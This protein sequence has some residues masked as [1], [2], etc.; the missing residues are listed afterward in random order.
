[1]GIEETTNRLNR[2]SQAESE[3]EVGIF[4][5][6]GQLEHEKLNSQL[7]QIQ[8]EHA[9]LSAAVAGEAEAEQVAAFVKKLEE[10]IPS[11]EDRI[12]IW[13]TLRKKDALSSFLR[14]APACTTRPMMLTSPS[15]VRPCPRS[16]QA[17]SNNCFTSFGH[18]WPRRR[19]QKRSLH[20]AYTW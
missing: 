10:Q 15:E 7:L 6:Q 9:K 1:M 4:K 8:H 12:G 19:T 3:N 2:L 16:E 5:L 18:L 14:E 13:Q 17:L 20:G 11:L